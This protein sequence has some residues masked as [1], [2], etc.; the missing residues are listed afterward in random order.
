MVVGLNPNSPS[1]RREKDKERQRKQKEREKA[2]Q[3]GQMDE[4]IHNWPA[5][6]SRR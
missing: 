6:R 1:K 5:P 3:N 2:K 4:K